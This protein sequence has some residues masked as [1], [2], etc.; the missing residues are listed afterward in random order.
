MYE[1]QGTR[2][3]IKDFKVGEMNSAYIIITTS[4]CIIISG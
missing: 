2:E 3:N 1:R 4:I